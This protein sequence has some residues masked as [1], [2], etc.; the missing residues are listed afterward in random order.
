MRK[1]LYILLSL[2]T[3][4]TYGQ[5]NRVLYDAPRYSV[6]DTGILN[7]TLGRVNFGT[8]SALYIADG[9]KWVKL[10]LQTDVGGGGTPAGNSGE[11]QF[12]DGGAFGA[13]SDLSWNTSNSRL[14]LLNLST[15]GQFR[16]YINGSLKFSLGGANSYLGGGIK[17]GDLNFPTARLHVKGSGSTSATTNQLNVNAIGDELFKLT[18]DGVATF[19]TGKVAIGATAANPSAIL[20]VSSTTKAFLPPRMTTAEMNAIPSPEGGMIVYDTTNNVMMYYNGTAWQ[21]F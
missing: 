12:N 8:D 19:E 3:L 10:S 11:I 14:E 21:P 1:H 7:P 20:E 4:A 2:I 17:I 13:S 9:N 18:D 5:R 16:H 6:I 15:V